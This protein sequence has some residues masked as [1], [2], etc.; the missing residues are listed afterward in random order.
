MNASTLSIDR[1]RPGA[2]YRQL[3]E[4][5]RARIAAG[6]WQPEQAIPS[7]REM[8]RATRLSRMTVRQAIAELTHEGLLR[9]DHGRGTFVV[10]PRIQQ[11]VRGVYSFTAGIRAQGRTPGTRLLERSVVPASDEQAAILT[12]EPGEPLIRLARLRLVDG[13]PVMVDLVHVPYRLCRDLLE[14][15]LSGSL[16]EL[17]TERF[18][19]PP[20]RSTDTIEAIAASPELAATLEV[21][22]GS[23]LILMR[24]LA[25]THD[26]VPLELTEEYAR[27][28]RCRYR[29]SLVAEAPTIELAA[30]AQLVASGA[31]D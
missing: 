3:T 31:S 14:V 21:A 11:V 17:L 27:P 15:D 20:L 25:L 9:R 28:D 5:L 26:D 18:G 2:V 16:Y 13:E 29:I 19:L 30:G 1:S 4:Q 10:S 12:L 22:A 24:R 23:P 7:E 6:E 8:M